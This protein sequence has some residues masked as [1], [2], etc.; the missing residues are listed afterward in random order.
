MRG[1]KT[2]VDYKTLLSTGQRVT[3]SQSS[4][5]IS[6]EQYSFLELTSNQSKSLSS[7]DISITEH[8][9]TIS[10]T[11]TASSTS[12]QN[13]KLVLTSASLIQHRHQHCIPLKTSRSKI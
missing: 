3:K 11:P 13:T 10:I 5:E 7:I 8:L 2:R 12:F 9:S 4:E 1:S 6:Q